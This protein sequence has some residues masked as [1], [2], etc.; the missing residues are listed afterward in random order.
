[1]NDFDVKNIP[2]TK[3]MFFTGK[4]GV[5]KHQ[6]PVLQ[7]LLLI[8]VLLVSTASNKTFSQI[9]QGGSKKSCCCKP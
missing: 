8:V 5:G 1:M 3:Y 7:R 4:G 6:L 9:N 2:L